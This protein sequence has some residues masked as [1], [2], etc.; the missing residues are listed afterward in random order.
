[1]AL[2][3]DRA[4]LRETE[5]EVSHQVAF[6][7][8]DLD[9]NLVLTATNFNRRIASQRNVEAIQATI[10]GG[11]TGPDYLNILLNTRNAARRRP[12]AITIAR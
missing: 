5:L 1:M 4:K 7:I 3:R 11:Q 10:D 12:I 6:A 8:R 2:A 9:S